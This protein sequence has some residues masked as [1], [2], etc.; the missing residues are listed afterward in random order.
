MRCPSDVE[1]ASFAHFHGSSCG[2]QDL[3]HHLKMLN[4]PKVE[5]VC[6]DNKN[7]MPYLCYPKSDGVRK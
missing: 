7:A 1:N 4:G 3:Q 6:G 2:S 5:P